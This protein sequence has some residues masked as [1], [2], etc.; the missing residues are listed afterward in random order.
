MDRFE[1]LDKGLYRLQKEE[2][3]P[4]YYGGKTALRYLCAIPYGILYPCV[5]DLYHA[6]DITLPNWFKKYDWTKTLEYKLEK[7]VL[8]Y[9]K[10]DFLATDIGF[11]EYTFLKPSIKIA[12]YE[13]AILEFLHETPEYNAICLGSDIMELM[14]NLNPD[15]LQ[16]LLEGCTCTKTKRLFLY[17]SEKWELEY[18]PK[19]DLSKIYLGEK[20]DITFKKNEAKWETLIFNPKYNMHL[21]KSIEKSGYAYENKFFEK[22]LKEY[23]DQKLS[24]E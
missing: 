15:I 8:L 19:L 11:I 2:G 23:G 5:I 20:V 6:G 9:F 14:D 16:P 13:R 4:I 10:N 21:P 3:I 7:L 18:L 1:S 22:L 24:C 12:G 17:F